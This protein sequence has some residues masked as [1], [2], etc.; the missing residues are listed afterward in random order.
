MI[1]Y[2]EDKTF[3][4]QFNLSNTTVLHILRK[5]QMSFHRICS[6]PYNILVLVYRSDDSRTSYMSG[7]SQ[8][9]YFPLEAGHFYFI[10]AGHS[11]EYNLQP[12]IQY[13]TFHIG[14]EVYPG[15]DLY[16]LQTPCVSGDGTA[17]IRKLDRIWNRQED[18]LRKA[19][20]IRVLLLQFFLEHWPEQ[21]DQS[22]NIPE[23]FQ[24]LPALLQKECDA[25]WTISRLADEFGL[26]P[27]AFTRKFRTFFGITPKKYME[28]ILMRK[29][30]TLLSRKKM[31]LRAVANELHFSSEFYLSRFIRKNTGI[32]VSK[33]RKQLQ[34]YPGEW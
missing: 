17:L 20:A 9:F 21:N 29:V 24:N 5:E 1:R 14:F 22:W 12:D 26:S 8:N 2:V 4:K 10:P 31:T 7:K 25:S 33:F 19:C 13:Y 34:Q 3:L 15:M 11:V 23:E 18:P 16:S 32:P 30:S 6:F 28:S 27:D